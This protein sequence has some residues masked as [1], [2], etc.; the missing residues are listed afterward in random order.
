MPSAFRSVLLGYRPN[1]PALNRWLG[2]YNPLVWWAFADNLFSIPPLV[3]CKVEPD[4]R[5][6]FSDN[7][8]LTV[9]Q[10]YG[11]EHSSELAYKTKERTRWRQAVKWMLGDAIVL[12]ITLFV[13]LISPALDA[14]TIISKGRMI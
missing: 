9:G 5:K 10:I 7:S 13:M 6:V 4:L 11:A 1:V 3:F 2:L 12:H 8:V 14:L